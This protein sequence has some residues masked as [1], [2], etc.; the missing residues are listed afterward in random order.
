[1]LD[2]SLQSSAKYLAAMLYWH[3]VHLNAQSEP[4]TVDNIKPMYSAA[5][6]LGQTSVVL[7]TGRCIK[8]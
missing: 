3:L 6:E 1:M 4:D 7:V 2:T 8:I 5:S